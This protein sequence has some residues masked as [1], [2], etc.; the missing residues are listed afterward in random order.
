MMTD[1]VLRAHSTLQAAGL[2]A[3]DAR[4]DA[5]LLARFALGWDA[6]TWLTRRK[7]PAPAGFE[8]AFEALIAR[9]AHREPVAYITGTREFFGR[10]FLVTADVL[11]PRPETEL[12]IE[13]ALF[14]IRRTRSWNRTA[15]P[16]IA[17]VGTGSGCIAVTL[18]LELPAARLIATDTSTAALDVAR[19]NARR[20][21]VADRIEFR[22][23]PYFAGFA[24]PVDLVVS[25]PPYV[26]ER[27]RASLAPE[28]ARFEPAGALFAGADGLD[29]IRALVPAAAAALQPGGGLIMEVGFGQA[30][31]VRL[32]AEA[33]RFDGV[34]FVQDL[35]DI[36]RIVVGRSPMA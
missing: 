7:E 28:V 35:R 11:I 5:G 2:T 27:D 8:P 36:S 19:D 17:D 34:R 21:G 3:E 14:L 12:L 23:G 22:H 1:L 10:P 32:I 13:E 9:R 30:D 6:T 4:R 16:L 26:P 24:S 29:A 15:S 20:H 31:A 18:A 25:N 33:S